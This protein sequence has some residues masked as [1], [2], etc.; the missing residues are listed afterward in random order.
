MADPEK[1]RV[2]SAFKYFLIILKALNFENFERKGRN[3]VVQNVCL[4]CGVTLFVALMP[5]TF[6]LGLWYI[7]DYNCKIKIIV[8]VIPPILTVLQ[9]F[10]TFITLRANNRVISETIERIQELID[11][12]KCIFYIFPY[13]YFAPVA[14]QGGA[15]CKLGRNL[16][17]L[18]QTKPLEKK[19]LWNSC[20]SPPSAL[21]MLEICTDSLFSLGSKESQQS[22]EVYEQVDRRYTVLSSFL[23]K[24]FT[25]MVASAYF[26]SAMF[27]VSYAIFDFPPP[28][29]WVQPVRVQ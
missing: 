7:Y 24:I 13:E 8:I 12:R 20:R 3:R 5:I 21:R 23:T 28:Q 1:L 11:Q 6:M 29:V 26:A 17:Y 19:N 27:P 10:L 2:F 15:K 16:P 9:L 14:E 25:F 4:A 18:M 22:F